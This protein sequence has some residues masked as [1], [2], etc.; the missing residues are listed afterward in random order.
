MP[1]NSAPSAAGG[2]STTSMRASS[3]RALSLWRGGGSDRIFAAFQCA[4][5]PLG[6]TPR[7]GKRAQCCAAFLPRRQ[8]GYLGIFLGLFPA[9]REGYVGIFEPSKPRGNSTIP[10]C[11]PESSQAD[12]PARSPPKDLALKTTPAR[13]RRFQPVRRRV[14]VFGV[15]RILGEISHKLDS[16]RRAPY[17]NRAQPRAPPPRCAGRPPRPSRRTCPRPPTPRRRR[18]SRWRPA[19]PA[20][21]W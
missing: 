8:T 18:R 1:T 5:P 3:P 13:P 20:S 21:T 2:Y 14:V 9:G 6:L 15:K 12:F 4:E 11:I 19:S 10:S 17:S 7:G 16:A